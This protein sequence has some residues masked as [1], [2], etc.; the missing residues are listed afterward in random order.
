M[1]ART[2]E[3][4]ME[5]YVLAVQYPDGRQESRDLGPG[6]YRIGRD[7]GDIILG[8]PQVSSSHAELILGDGRATFTDLGSRNG[9]VWRGQRLSGS[10]SL[11]EQELVALGNSSIALL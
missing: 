8:D 5:I 2:K 10:V 11:R 4:T 6:R 9:S 7:E 1:T 3:P